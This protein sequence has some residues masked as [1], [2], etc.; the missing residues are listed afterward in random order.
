M[1]QF[2][3]KGLVQRDRVSH[4]RQIAVSAVR[5]SAIVWVEAVRE[6]AIGSGCFGEEIAKA[7]KH[8]TALIKIGLRRTS[9]EDGRE[10]P[11]REDQC[12]D[13][14]GRGHGGMVKDEVRQCNGGSVS[15]PFPA[16]SKRWRCRKL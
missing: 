15:Q 9:H 2:P 13:A 7:G 6:R 1:W 16:L 11:K 12:Q 3:A 14:G 4:S 10:T 5:H 8:V